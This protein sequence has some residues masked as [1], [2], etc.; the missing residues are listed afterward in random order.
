LNAY[1]RIWQVVISIS[2]IVILS[3]NGAAQAGASAPEL[4]VGRE[5]GLASEAIDC[6]GVGV[7][8]VAPAIGTLNLR[9]QGQVERARLIVGVV[10]TEAAHT[11]KLNGQPVAQAPISPEGQPCSDGAV[12]F[13]DVS[14]AVVVQGN[15]QIEITG[16]ALSG[17]AWTIAHVRLEVFGD[18]AVVDTPKPAGPEP[19]A[20]PVIHDLSFPQV[21]A[22]TVSFTSSFDGS[23]QEFK[24]QVPVANIIDDCDTIA[25][26]PLLIYGHGRSQSYM[27]PF[28]L[29][30]DTAAQNN[31]WLL[32]SPQ[33]HGSWPGSVMFPIPNPPGAY[34][35]A[36]RE[37]QY[38]IV[39]TVKTMIDLCN[40]KLDQIYYYGNSMGA[41]TGTVAVAKW[42]H[43]FAAIFD[44]KGPT[45]MASWYDPNNEGAGSGFH[46]DW[47]ERE[48][49]I[50]GVAKTPAQNPFCYQRRSSLY[51]ASNYIHLPISISHSIEDELVGIYHSRNLRDAIEAYNPDQPVPLF[52]DPD[53]NPVCGSPPYHCYIPDVQ[54]VIDFLGGHTLDNTHNH[55][56][57]TTDESKTYYWL[58]IE[59]VGG[60]E[61]FT[62]VEATYNSAFKSITAVI[63]DTGQL[64]LGFNLGSTQQATDI[65]PLPSLGFPE[66]RSY[67]VQETGQADYEKFYTSGYFEVD[68][69]NTGQ[70]TLTIS[71]NLFGPDAQAVYLPVIRK[72]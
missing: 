1:K 72:N 54:D 17:D 41:Q 18:L 52:E 48:C 65:I 60:G 23:P 47:M 56:N 34:A 45:D 32:A 29:D 46:R 37:A 61:R 63:S 40:V 14:P 58:D 33:L 66:N 19:T 67:L 51:F 31:G 57:I 55:I 59:Q 49:H 20:P 3:M 15:N 42:P 16:D 69:N 12:Y 71:T 2:F 39:D 6:L 35:Y 22:P 11:I 21:F 10:G 5:I 44:N 30:F 68:L 64:R 28:D 70:Y 9:W 13:L 36:S 7:G 43:L 4:Q 24:A 38:D 27:E 26:T 62:Q 50:G 53:A 25:P 8:A